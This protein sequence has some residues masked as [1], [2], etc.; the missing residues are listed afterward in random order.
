MLVDIAPPRRPVVHPRGRR[1]DRDRRAHPAP[2]RGEQRGAAASC[3]RSWPYTA[4]QI[5]DPQ[6]RHMGTIGGSVA[7]A[8]PASDM[9]TVM[10]ALGAEFVVRG[11]ERRERAPSPASRLLPGLFEPDLAAER[12]ARRDP[13]AEDE[14]RLELPE[15]PPPRAGLGDGRRGGAS[16]ANGRRAV[17]LTNMGDRRRCA[18]PASRRRSR[19]APTRRRPPPAPTRARRRRPMRSAAP[20]TAGSCSKVLVRRALEEALG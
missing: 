9:R 12:G 13:R 8:D 2:R 14:R 7:H 15:V 5:G 1:R 17:A 18:R 11:A 10:L 16:Q 19:A 3:A 20:S 6:V 4:E